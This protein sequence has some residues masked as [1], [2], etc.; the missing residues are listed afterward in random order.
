M[1]RSTFLYHASRVVLSTFDLDEVLHQ[2]L[3]IIQVHFNASNSAVLLLDKEK[4][5]LQLRESAGTAAKTLA[6]IPVGKGITGMAASTKQPVYVPDVKRDTRYVEGFTGTRSEL[7]LPLILRDEVIGVL[8]I[9]SNETDAFNADTIRLLKLFSLQASVSIEN[10]RLF[11]L[12]KLRSSQLDAINAI[13]RQTA[14][15]LDI[16]Q[17]LPSVAELIVTRF[18]VDHVSV[19][20]KRE[21]VLEVQADEGIMQAQKGELSIL[22]MQYLPC[23]SFAL[24]EPVVEN[25]IAT[26]EKAQ[27]IHVGAVAEAAIPLTFHGDRLGVLS[28]ASIQAGQFTPSFLEPLAAVAD[29]LA[30]AI[31]NGQQLEN[32]KQLAYRDG[33]TGIFNRRFFEERVIEEI[34]RCKR[35]STELGVLL[36]DIDHFKAVNDDFGHLQGDEVLR[37]ITQIFLQQMRKS[38]IVC[39][40]GGEEF[41]ILL[42]QI[43]RQHAMEAAE[44]LRRIIEGFSFPGIQRPVTVSVGVAHFPDNGKSRDSLVGAADTALYTAKQK[45]RNTVELA[46]TESMGPMLVQQAEMK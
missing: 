35:Y 34:D 11:T 4:Q 33:L 2:I 15:Q 45:G 38:D 20:L 16:N 26:N 41:V 13:A 37:Q 39:R 14:A 10:A 42:P 31:K 43:D 7:A 25:Q 19:L 23:M 6:V 17:L 40:Y 18:G 1:D 29:I 22:S 9:Q 12:E 8:D 44:K 30:G 28:F 3:A 32:T 36:I 21:S 27:P 24:Q 5:E 46:P